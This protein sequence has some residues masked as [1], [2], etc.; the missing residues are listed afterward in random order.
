[1]KAENRM[2]SEVLNGARVLEIPFFQRSY[3]WKEDQW[4]R[5]MAD[6]EYVSTSNQEYF[7]GSLILK[8]L[9]TPANAKTSIGKGS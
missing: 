7:M 5:M 3:V 2:L 8:R 1:M 6:M 9:E 4:K